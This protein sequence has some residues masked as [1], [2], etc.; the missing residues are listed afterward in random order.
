MLGQKCLVPPEQEPPTPEQEEEFVK[1]YNDQLDIFQKKTS[2]LSMASSLEKERIEPFTAIGLII[3][4]GGLL[5]SLYQWI[6]GSS[7]K[8]TRDNFILDDSIQELVGIGGELKATISSMTA[9]KKVFVKWL[10]KKGITEYSSVIAD[11]PRAELMGE[12]L[13]RLQ[14]TVQEAT[15]ALCQLASSAM[16][17]KATGDQSW[18]EVCS[19][20]GGGS[21]SSL[22][23][24]RV[25]AGG[26][27]ERKQFGICCIL[28]G[29]LIGGAIAGGAAGATAASSKATTKAI[30]EEKESPPDEFCQSHLFQRLSRQLRNGRLEIT[31]IFNGLNSW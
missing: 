17:E 5:M 22:A 12:T 29:I 31:T 26:A 24:E 15:Q 11:F 19:P 9:H 7:E 30:A 25:T 3:S 27:L 14:H 1:L 21:D 4:A 2:L 20:S 10:K 23:L 16:G 8:T 18:K 28:V 6:S 13:A